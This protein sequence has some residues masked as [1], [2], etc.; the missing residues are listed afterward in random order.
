MFG[1]FEPHEIGSAH[2][3]VRENPG[4][5]L[6]SLLE[7]LPEWCDAADAVEMWYELE[8]RGFVTSEQLEEEGGKWALYPKEGKS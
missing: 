6:S 1:V 5:S 2:K 8:S 7:A 4:C 3:H